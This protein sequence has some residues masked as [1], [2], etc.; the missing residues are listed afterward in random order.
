MDNLVSLIIPAAG[1]STRF[2]G[3]PK[4]LLTC[5]D[6]DIMIQKCIKG[7]DLTNVSDIYFTF[8]KEHVDKYCK[9]YDMKDLFKFTSKNIHI[10]LLTEYTKSQ[11]ETVYKTIIQNN[12]KGSIFIKD[13]DNYFKTNIIAE[14]YVNTLLINNENNVEELHNKSFIERNNLGQITNICEKKIISNKICVGGYSFKNADFFKEMYNNCIKTKIDKGELYISN[15]IFRS[16]LENTIFY[17]KDV[18]EYIDWGTIK[19]WRKYC[20][21]F[22]TLFVDIDGT[23]VYNSGEYFK[24]T[25]GDT[26]P[27]KNNVKYLQELYNKGRTK[28]ILTTARKYSSKEKTIAQLKKYNIPYDKIIFDLYHTKRILIND[29]AT[30]NPFPTAVS[31][32]LNR[33]E[34]IKNVEI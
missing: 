11:S 3:K 25:W 19:E 31:I 15:I 5:P 2:I 27:L 10:L 26:E 16:I 14:N 6:G 20:D 13:C 21:S 17:S 1:K 28:I 34:G 24:P 22:K 9:D 8:L 33:N 23:L 12:I 30:T 29:F 18:S 4:W 32:N 7:L